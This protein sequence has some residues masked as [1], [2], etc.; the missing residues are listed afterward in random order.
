VQENT[1]DLKTEVVEKPKEH[2]ND[3]SCVQENTRDSELEKTEEVKND[4]SCV[5]EN[6]RDSELEKTEEVKNDIS[7][8]QEN[9]RDLKTEVVE[10]P[11]EHENDISCV[12]ENTRDLKTE[13][14]EKP[15]EHED[16]ISCVQEN[17][18][19]LKTEVVEKPNISPKKKNNDNQ[20][21]KNGNLDIVDTDDN[22]EEEEHEDDISCVQEN[23]RDSKTKIV[24]KPNISPKKKNNDNQNIKNGN[25]DIVDTDDNIEEEEDDSHIELGV[26]IPSTSYSP[27]NDTESV[28]KH[29]LE[30]LEIKIDEKNL[31]K[32]QLG[33]KKER[34]IVVQ[35]IKKVNKEYLPYIERGAYLTD[36]NKDA[37]VATLVLNYS[38]AL[39]TLPWIPDEKWV[40]L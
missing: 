7:C 26:D 37:E 8:V 38:Y 39:E 12:Q 18:R 31:T 2:E 20:N 11:K 22:I 27:P 14:V 16:D 5:Q 29:N 32:E 1:R 21:I 33:R 10:K 30:Q 15:K 3:I 24:E 36:N 6:T 9:T 23:T 34:D 40:R 4:I 13:V 28:K 25:L 19:D 17:T 35:Y